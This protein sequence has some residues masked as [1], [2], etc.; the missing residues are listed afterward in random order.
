MEAVSDI[1]TVRAHEPAGLRRMVVASLG[2]HLVVGA[3]VLF[4]PS[5]NFGSKEPA[6]VMTISLGG[7][8]G[9]RAGGMTPMGGQAVQAQRPPELKRVPVEPPAAKA[10]EMAL[11]AP[12]VK[13]CAAEADR[14]GGS[15]RGTIEDAGVWRGT[16]EGQH[17]GADRR[18][19][20]RL[21]SHDRRWWHRRLSRCR[22][23]LLPRVSEQHGAVDPAEL[24]RRDRTWLARP[25][26][27]SSSRV[28]AASP[29]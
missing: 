22:E 20:R 5:G 29:T 27:V 23:L 17:D 1:L 8:P 12:K 14:A 4:M 26:S 15:A 19:G 2:L 13:P 10:P 6:T 11:P 3:V 25:R 21:W 18:H 16:E 24:E 9:P 7:A 28:T